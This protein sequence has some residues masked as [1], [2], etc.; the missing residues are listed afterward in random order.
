MT[1]DKSCGLKGRQKLFF[2]HLGTAAS[3]CKAYSDPLSSFDNIKQLTD[4]WDHQRELLQHGHEIPSCNFCWQRESQGQQSYRHLK[5]KEAVNQIE[6]YLDNT[7]NQMCGYCGPKFSSTWENSISK[8]GLFRNVSQ[9]ANEN[10][11]VLP[12]TVDTQ[13]WLDQVHQYIQQQPD[14]TVYLKLL[15]GEPLMQIK[16]LEKLLSFNSNK[17]R[18]LRINTNLNPP[19]NKF[20]LWLLENVPVNQMFFDV[21]LD[22]TPEF[23]HVPRAGF[24]QQR[25]LENLELLQQ[26]RVRYKFLSVVSVLNIFG[27]TQFLDWGKNNNHTIELLPINNPECLD[28]KFIPNSFKDQI[29]PNGLPIFV[30]DIL[31]SCNT[32]VDTKL[33]E[34]YNYLLEYFERTQ[35]NPVHAPNT[36]FVSYWKYLTD[37]FA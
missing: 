31:K 36:M 5:V 6:L 29:N 4:S 23:N 26:H 34:Q 10:L 18:Q 17:I 7:C 33:H 1:Q 9:D 37:R 30:Q 21:S 12:V 15:G 28:P 35:I 32:T 3:C 8:H 11:K 2:L 16:H 27:L 14:N 24:D 22:A 19:N 25:F 13:Y 20:L